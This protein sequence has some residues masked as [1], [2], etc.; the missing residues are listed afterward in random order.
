MFRGSILRS[1]DESGGG[2]GTFERPEHITEAE[3]DDL[4]ADEREG[5]TSTDEGEGAHLIL[6]TGEDAD[7]QDDEDDLTPEEL[8]A[9]LEDKPAEGKTAEELAAEAAATGKTPEEIAAEAAAAATKTPEELAAEAAAALVAGPEVTDADLIA[10]RPTVSDSELAFAKETPPEIQAKLD[11]IKQ[12]VKDARAKFSEGDLTREAL[13][14]II[15]AAADKRDA[16]NQELTEAKITTRDKL[17][18]ALLWKKG[19]NAFFSARKEYGEADTAADGTKTQTER[20]VMLH[21]ALNAQIQR[22][23]SL[24]GSDTKTD[25]QI[26]VESDKA[27][28]KLFNLPAGKPAAAATVTI[29]GKEKPAAVNRPALKEVSEKT[30]SGVP[31]AEGEHVDSMA[32]AVTRLNGPKFEATLDNMTDAQRRALEDSV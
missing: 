30:L 22:L 26:L 32:K 19:C 17:R 4:S 9:I 27:V 2:G 29:P 12:E 24:P 28:R 10:Y 3:W 7:D 23:N 11:A 1:P 13:D 31:V 5:L 25:M 8:A 21:A 14:D 20:A 18:D 15:D 16:V 6:G